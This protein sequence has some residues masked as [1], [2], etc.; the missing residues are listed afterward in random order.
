MTRRFLT[1][2]ALSATLALSACESSEERA[3]EF[4]QTGME[5]LQAG[6]VD[7]AIVSFRNVFRY[8]GEH[9]EAR[10]EL[11]DALYDRG[12]RQEAYSQY[13]RLAEQYPDNALVRQQL[14]SMA[15]QGQAWDE[16]E[17]HGRRALELAPDAAINPPIRLSLD[18]RAAALAEWRSLCAA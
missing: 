2:L 14:T 18:Y 17:R 4:Y 12:D 13:L 16:A 10:K 7:R 3:E 8:N 5:L 1:A 9:F 15:L 11:A 6:D